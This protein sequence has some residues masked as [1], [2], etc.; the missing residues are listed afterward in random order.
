MAPPSSKP[1]ERYTIG[2]PSS[3]QTFTIISSSEARSHPIQPTKETSSSTIIIRWDRWQRGR[4]PFDRRHRHPSP[5]PRGW[6]KVSCASVIRH[7]QSP[8]LLSCSNQGVLASI[9]PLLFYTLSPDTVSSISRGRISSIYSRNSNMTGITPQHHNPVSMA[10]ASLTPGEGFWVDQVQSVSY[11]PM[12]RRY[13][14]H[15]R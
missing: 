8:R 14:I 4:K 7:A 13:T 9:I 12:N 15:T 2:S 5:R 1:M 6:W 10:A 3:Q 11:S